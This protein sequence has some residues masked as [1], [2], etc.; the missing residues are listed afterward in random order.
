MKNNKLLKKRRVPIEKSKI[1]KNKT[2]NVVSWVDFLFSTRRWLF[3]YDCILNEHVRSHRDCYKWTNIKSHLNRSREYRALHVKS[4]TGTL[5]P[6]E[7]PRVI[8]KQSSMNDLLRWTNKRFSFLWIRNSKSHW[9]F[10]IWLIFVEVLKSKQRREKI[11]N[12]KHGGEAFQIGGAA[13]K[14]QMSQVLSVF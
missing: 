8:V 2:W 1:H 3:A 14:Q 11:K 13:P 6:E 10:W 9:T 12:Q 7:A 4:L 5:T